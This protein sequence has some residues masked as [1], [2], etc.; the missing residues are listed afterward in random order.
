MG[1]RRRVKEILISGLTLAL[2]M[3]ACGGGGSAAG[4]AGPGAVATLAPITDLVQ[5]VAGDRINVKT[6]VPEGQDA[7]TY[8][9]IP[10]DARNLAGVDLFFDNGWGL[11]Q[12]ILQFAADNLGSEVR[13]VFLG[14]QTVPLEDLIAEPSA[15][16]HG[17]DKGA[18]GFHCHGGSYNAHMWPDIR[19]AIRY[20]KEIEKV[21]S[22]EDPEGED[23]YRAN[24]DALVEELEKLDE[25]TQD[26]IDSIPPE[27]RKLVVYHDSWSY[28]AR[29]YG[30]EVVGAIQPADFTEPSAAELRDMIEQIQDEGVPAFFGSEVFPSDVLETVA[31]E[32]GADYVAD[33]ADDD[34]PG[35][36]GD[37]DHSYI[38]L[39]VSNVRIMADALGGDPAPLEG[40]DPTAGSSS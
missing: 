9:P 36:D 35:S 32:S 37:D 40:I 12:S 31:Q 34:L 19:Y 17:G 6:L 5:R 24:A 13:P 2:F 7:H 1:R 14:E 15:S 10:S 27:N 3:S 8:Q 38:G 16:C 21:L 23:D 39:M 4:G 26:V 20:V 29:R 33:L 25:A 22:E 18:P 30:M 11:N 28:F